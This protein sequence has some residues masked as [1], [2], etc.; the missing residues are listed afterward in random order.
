MKPPFCLFVCASEPVLS[1]L[2]SLNE[3]ER[4]TSAVDFY[5]DLINQKVDSR[6]V[7]SG[8]ITSEAAGSCLDPLGIFLNTQIPI[9]LVQ[10]LRIKNVEKRKV[11]TNPF[12]LSIGS[13]FL[14]LITCDLF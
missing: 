10:V 4:K 3:K 13:F 12:L 8:L 1:L 6:C 11:R 5:L 14:R 2:L 7:R 9:R